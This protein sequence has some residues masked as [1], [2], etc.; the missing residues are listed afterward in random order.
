M[1]RPARILIGAI[2]LFAMA[3]VHVFKPVR[4]FECEHDG[5]RVF[6]LQDHCHGPH[7]AAC[8]DHDHEEPCHSHD[9]L[10]AGDDTEHHT[11]LV[12]SLT[13]LKTDS[14]QFAAVLAVAPATF[15]TI[16]FPPVLSADESVLRHIAAH[17]DGRRWPRILSHCIALLI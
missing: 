13:A 4:G 5:V 16:A 10:P 6:T 17:P 8:H 15:E 2:A 12:E 7:S 11:A 3:W 14:F 1:K 9:D